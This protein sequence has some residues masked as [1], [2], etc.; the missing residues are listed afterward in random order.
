MECVRERDGYEV[1]LGEY[2]AG[3]G[4]EE[5]IEI[6]LQK[7]GSVS[8]CWQCSKEVSDPEIQGC[9]AEQVIE[10]DKD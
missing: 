9:T 1:L 3:D 7:N 8:V 10:Q 5:A 6:A 2:E 4:S